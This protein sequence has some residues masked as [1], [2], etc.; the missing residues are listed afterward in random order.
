[1]SQREITL[2]LVRLEQR[3]GHRIRPESTIY[4]V[5]RSLRCRSAGDG[6]GALSFPKT[7]STTSRW[8]SLQ[9]LFSWAMGRGTRVCP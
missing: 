3:L 7:F 9:R 1:L 6:A 8:T 2:E 4:T 5:C